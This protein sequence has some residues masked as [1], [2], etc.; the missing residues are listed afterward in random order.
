MKPSL[1]LGDRKGIQKKAY[2][3]PMLKEIQLWNKVILEGD[4]AKNS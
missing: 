3:D 2:C 1:Y 4:K